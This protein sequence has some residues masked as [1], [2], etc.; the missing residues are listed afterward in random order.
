M[1]GEVGAVDSFDS[2]VVCSTFE[3][4]GLAIVCLEK[5]IGML[6]DACITEVKSSEAANVIDSTVEEIVV[7]F[8]EAKEAIGA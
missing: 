7:Q 6:V 1:E 3:H 2:F 8:A 4:R 5:N